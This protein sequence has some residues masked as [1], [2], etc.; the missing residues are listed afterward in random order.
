MKRFKLEIAVLGVFLSLF[1]AFGTIAAAEDGVTKN[2]ILIGSTMDLSGPLAFMGQGWRDGANLYFRYI[3]DKGG[4]HGRKIKFL[5]EDDGFQAPR[6]VLGIKK[7]ITKDKVFA[8]S[9]NMGA[10]SIF[11]IL[12]LLEQ[13]KV[14]M[15]PCGSGNELLAIPPRKYV[16]VTETGYTIFGRLA[17]KFMLNSLK[18]TPQKVAIIYQDE[19]SGQQYRDGVKQGCQKYGLP[20]PLE[21]SFKKGATDFG[22]QIAIC[23]KN[24]INYIFLHAN[25]REPAFVMKEAQRIQYKATYIGLAPQGDNQTVKL[26]GDA[27]EF[28]N[29]Y[30]H[31]HNLMFENPKSATYKAFLE[32]VKKYNVDPAMAKSRNYEW[33]FSAASI[34]CEVLKRTGKDLTREGF[35][36]AAESL[37]NFDNGTHNPITFAPDRRDGGRAV[38]IFK[39][40]NGVW[41][42][43]GDGKWVTE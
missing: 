13:Y 6:T 16:F 43:Y 8:M 25:V 26:A 5:V 4:I 19:V 12:P 24:N 10:S 3:N 7:L 1:F 15:L 34:L 42:A 23:K 37:K 33:A 20:A 38:S 40:Q 18:A 29:G 30:Y 36:K 27:V 35:V 39:A 14:P 28:S 31:L 41:N 11:A 9:L 21:L 22:S 32:A 2:E 17:V